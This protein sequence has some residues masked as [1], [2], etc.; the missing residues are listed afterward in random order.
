MSNYILVRSERQAELEA[1]KAAFFISGNKVQVLESL[2]WRG[3]FGMK[4]WPS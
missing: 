4:A 2:T 1:A 3:Y